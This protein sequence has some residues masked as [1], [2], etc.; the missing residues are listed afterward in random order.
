MTYWA[1]KNLD[2]D[3]LKRQV[4]DAIEA[5]AE[6]IMEI[7][8]TIWETP[9]PGYKEYKTAE[10]VASKFRELGLEVETGVGITGVIAKIKG[11]QARPNIAVQGELDALIIPEHPEADEKYGAV[12]ACGHN[13]QITNVIALAMGLVDTGAMKELDGTVTLM[14]VPSEEPIEIEWRQQMREEGKLFFLGGKQEFIKAGKFDDVDISFIDHMGGGP[15]IK[16]SVRS[17][18]PAPGSDGFVAKMITFKGAEAHSGGAPWLGVNAL[19]ACML[20]LMGIHAQRETF[21]DADAIRVHQIIT[22]GGDSVN[23]VPSDVR[24]EMMV[25]GATVE[26]I[27]DASMKVDRAFKAG[28]MAVG[29]EVEIITIPGYLPS[30]GVKPAKLYSI[31]Y[32]NAVALLGEKNVGKG[33]RQQGLVKV[34]SGVVA[35]SA[36]VASIIP[37]GGLGVSGSEGRGHSREYRIVDPYNAYVVPAKIYAMAIIDLL[38]DGAVAAKEIIAEFTPVVTKEDYMAYWKDILGDQ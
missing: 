22:K 17:A 12:H 26:A 29:G 2:R 23:V 35:D 3:G 28:A 37:H 31:L 5:R 15:D 27:K 16:I 30:P 10:L 25:R 24:M 13:A 4:C 21:K 38:A 8:K 11:S 33:R 1:V 14:G 36:D 6:E 32:E 18:K 9:E 19:N 20:G 34:P 7:G